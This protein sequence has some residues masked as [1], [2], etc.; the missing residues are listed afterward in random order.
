MIR[1][2]SPDAKPGD[3]VAIYD[4]DDR[5]FG[6]GLWNP[7][8]RVPLRAIY[9][10]HDPFTEDDFIRLLDRAVDLRLTTLGLPEHTDAF[11]VV[12]SDG[13]A[14]SGLIVDRFGDV[15]SVS[16][17]SLGVYK[18][19]PQWLKHLHDRLGTLSTQP[20]T[21]GGTIVPSSLTDELLQL[22]V[23][24]RGQRNPLYA[25]WVLTA[26]STTCCCVNPFRR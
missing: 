12:H 9:H 8:A 18:R 17:H 10:G 25:Y 16:T 20:T 1:G 3:L 24:E 11:R 15:L 22:R 14:L 26:C 4:K 2:S 7:K 19:L 23:S 5:P 21:T 6:A 13:D